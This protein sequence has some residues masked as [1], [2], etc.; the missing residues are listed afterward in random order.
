M[1]YLMRAVVSAV[2]GS[3]IVF[4]AVAFT[5][6]AFF[7]LLLATNCIISREALICFDHQCSFTTTPVFGKL[8]FPEMGIAGSGM[9]KRS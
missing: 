3:E 2:P 8:G 4:T 1:L 5:L 9:V 7:T 6:I